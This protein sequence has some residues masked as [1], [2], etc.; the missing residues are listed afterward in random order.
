MAENGGGGE[1]NW[2]ASENFRT[3]FKITPRPHIVNPRTP[4]GIFRKRYSS[5]GGSF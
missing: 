4:T 3:F 1:K 5:G 2:M